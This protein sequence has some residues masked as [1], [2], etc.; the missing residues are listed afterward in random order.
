MSSPCDV[1]AIPDSE[2]IAAKKHPLRR[3]T[4]SRCFI[5]FKEPTQ[6]GLQRRDSNIVN[7]LISDATLRLHGYLA[8]MHRA[9]S[10]LAQRSAETASRQ[11]A[12]ENKRWAPEMT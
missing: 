1:G 5:M 9:K 8:N 4:F 3:L 7:A 12:R 10:V 2:T 6:Y 11:S